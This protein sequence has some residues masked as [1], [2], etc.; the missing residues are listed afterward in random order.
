[1]KSNLSITKVF[2][3]IADGKTIIV[4]SKHPLTGNEAWAFTP[5]QLEFLAASAGITPSQL[6]VVAPGCQLVVEGA[7]VKAGETLTNQRTGEV[8]TFTKDHFRVERSSIILSQKAQML[9]LV[10]GEVAQQ[11]SA[12]DLISTPAQDPQTVGEKEKVFQED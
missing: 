12:A 10:A 6:R 5:Q 7:P 3:R 4:T 9:A 2:H 1:M 8:I 11:F